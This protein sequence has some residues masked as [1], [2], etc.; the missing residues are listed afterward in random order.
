MALSDWDTL[1]IGPDG[2]ST[3]GAFTF[4]SGSIVEIYKNRVSLRGPIEGQLY[5][6]NVCLGSLELFAKRG[7][8][9]AV[10]LVAI[11]YSKNDSDNGFLKAFFG[12]I[13]CSGYRHFHKEWLE[14][15][16][17][18]TD[19]NEDEWW[20]YSQSSQQ[21]HEEII[22]K[23]DGRFSRAEDAD[24][25]IEYVIDDPDF[26]LTRWVGVEKETIEDYKSWLKELVEEDLGKDGEVWLTSINWDELTR[27]NQGDAFFA[28][29]F[30]TEIPATKPEETSEPVIN[31][32]IKAIKNDT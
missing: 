9:N 2:K 14:G 18:L 17:G 12:G 5:H 22:Y 28:S 4:P 16:E 6:G 32:M 23:K 25:P 30:S 20:H 24:G 29:A 11:D 3:N 8:Q 27:Y 1:A 21:G 15:H 10:F 13:G 7:R 31:N 26:E 19:I